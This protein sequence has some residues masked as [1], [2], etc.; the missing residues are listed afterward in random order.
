MY[1]RALGHAI[2]EGQGVENEELEWGFGQLVPL[3]FCVLPFIA[4]GESYWG[5]YVPNFQA[6]VAHKILQTNILPK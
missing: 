6:V 2:M 3:I 5:E 4:A 1:D